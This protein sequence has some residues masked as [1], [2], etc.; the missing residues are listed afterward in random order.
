MYQSISCSHAGLWL[1]DRG[2][3]AAHVFECFANGHSMNTLFDAANTSIDD[4]NNVK[5][6]RECLG[7]STRKFTRRVLCLLHMS[8]SVDNIIWFAIPSASSSQICLWSDC[9][10][11]NNQIRDLGRQFYDGKYNTHFVNLFSSV[12]DWFRRA[13]GE[14]LTNK[15]FGQDWARL[16]REFLSDSD[17]HAM[18]VDKV[19]IS[20]CWFVLL[21]S[22]QKHIW[23][24]EA[25][26]IANH[27]IL[28]HWRGHMSRHQDT[29]W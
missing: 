3:W 23:L 5:E 27:I 2:V 24:E 25:L 7:V 12:G 21:Q 11:H 14:Y 10:K 26:G 17:G 8:S 1:K 16:T 22:D 9:N 6:L 15:C 20:D 29:S 13:M 28:I 19:C 4:E 18:I